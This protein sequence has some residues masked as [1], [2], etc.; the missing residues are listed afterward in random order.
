MENGTKKKSKDTDFEWQKPMDLKMPN[1]MKGSLLE[2]KSMELGDS[3]I[4]THATLDLSRKT[5]Y[6]GLELIKL[7]VSNVLESSKTILSLAME[8]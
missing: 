2:V 6:M 7:K 1:F 3:S 4:R 5:S 8:F